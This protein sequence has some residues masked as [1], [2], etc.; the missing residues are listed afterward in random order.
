MYIQ[1]ILQ[2]NIVNFKKNR[3]EHIIYNIHYSKKYIIYLIILFCNL[4]L[5]SYRYIR[6]IRCNIVLRLFIQIIC[7]ILSIIIYKW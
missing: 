6:Y 5:Y 1:T 7:F 3:S 4:L 2:N